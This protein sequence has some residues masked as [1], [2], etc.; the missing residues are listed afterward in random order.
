MAKAKARIGPA[1]LGIK[2]GP[3]SDAAVF[4]W[5][6]ACQLFGARISQDIAARAFG[7]LDRA[8]VLSPAKLA[9]ADWQRLVDLLGA[10]GYRR[11]DESTARELI[12]VG[13][14]AVDKYGGKITRLRN[15]VTS[16]KELAE[17]LQEFKGIGPTAANIFLREM[18]P[19]WQL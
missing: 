5:L 4:R 6:V 12:D 13:R 7:E 16:K 2:L 19:V 15:G 8:G 1:E 18:A 10:G 17:R 11:Y 9:S 3:R 14:L